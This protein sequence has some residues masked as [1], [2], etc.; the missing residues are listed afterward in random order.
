MDDAL[1]QLL[2]SALSSAGRGGDAVGRSVLGARER[3]LDDARREGS[4]MRASLRFEAADSGNDRAVTVVCELDAGKVDDRAFVAIF[5]EHELPSALRDPSAPA[6]VRQQA[7]TELD[8]HLT[9]AFEFVPEADVGARRT[10]VKVALPSHWPSVRELAGPGSAARLVAVYAA[11]GEVCVGAS[12][13]LEHAPPSRDPPKAAEPG[14]PRSESPRLRSGALAYLLEAQQPSKCFVLHVRAPRLRRS[15]AGVACTWQWRLRGAWRVEVEFR[16]RGDGVSSAAAT[17]AT[18]DD[19]AGPHSAPSAAAQRPLPTGTNDDALW[20]CC[21]CLPCPALNT[22]AVAA[23]QVRAL[24]PPRAVLTDATRQAA[25][26]L[27]L[28]IPFHPTPALVPAPPAWFWARYHGHARRGALRHSRAIQ[29]G[30]PPGTSR[31]AHTQPLAHTT[32]GPAG[33]QE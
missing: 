10:S 19:A 21:V 25:S 32:G 30:L 4:A 12:A 23:Q 24:Q 14:R 22:Q 11:R 17:P 18:G 13:P 28:R 27:R 3:F 29:G 5:R 9:P 2:A 15:D 7:M 31:A 8:V 16:V 20:Q 1:Q 6:T 26:S 33:V